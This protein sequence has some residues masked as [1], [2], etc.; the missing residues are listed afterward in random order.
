VTVHIS[1]CTLQTRR[2]RWA[3]HV[4]SR[5]REKKCLL[6]LLTATEFSLGG[7]TSPYTSTDKP[8]KNKYM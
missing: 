6:L 4:T 7:G 2:Q 8:N 1:S 5:G 3:W